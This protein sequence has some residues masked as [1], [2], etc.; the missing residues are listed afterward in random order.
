MVSDS[1]LQIHGLKNLFCPFLSPSLPSGCL[2]LKPHPPRVWVLD[3]GQPVVSSVNPLRPAWGGHLR[4]GFRERT[5]GVHGPILTQFL[6]PRLCWVSKHGGRGGG[7][8]ASAPG[9]GSGCSSAFLLSTQAFRT[10]LPASLN[11]QSYVHSQPGPQPPFRES[12]T[13]R[14]VPSQALPEAGRT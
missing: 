4:M 1:V 10:P 5:T 11:P 12:H 7:A 6:S 13:V 14:R 3:G 2:S 9:G 8:G